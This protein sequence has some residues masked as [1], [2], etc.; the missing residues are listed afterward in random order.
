MEFQG[1]N[2]GRSCPC[3]VLLSIRSVVKLASTLANVETFAA[4]VHR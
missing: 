1:L 4:K 2:L 3:G